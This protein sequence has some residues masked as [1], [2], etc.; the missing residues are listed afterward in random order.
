FPAAQTLRQL[1]TR[2][3]IPAL[4]IRDHPAMPIRGTIEG[5]YGKPRSMA[6]RT[7]HLN[8]LGQMKANTYVY[9]PKDDP[10]ARDKWREAYPA[11]TLKA[12]GTLVA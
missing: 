1:L 6:D 8:F 3:T 2:K 7:K 5:F 10:F 11:E 4:T 12:L 9:S